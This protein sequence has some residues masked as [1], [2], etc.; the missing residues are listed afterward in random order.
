MNCV[1]WKNPF[2]K[3]YASYRNVHTIFSMGI[4][5]ICLGYFVRKSPFDG[6]TFRNYFSLLKCT[7]EHLKTN[8]GKRNQCHGY[9]KYSLIG[10]G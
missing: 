1:N 10:L 5:M 6:S 7:T 2:M 4:G 9:V 8:E 3:V